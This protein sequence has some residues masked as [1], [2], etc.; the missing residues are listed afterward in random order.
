MATTYRF[1][2]EQGKGGL[3]TKEAE[4]LKENGGLVGGAGK[5]GLAAGVGTKHGAGTYENRWLRIVNPAINKF[6][7]GNWEK[8]T[9]IGRGVATMPS[10]FASGGIG[11]VLSSTGFA[12][13]LQLA[14][15]MAIKEFEKMRANSLKE[16]NANFLRM[17]SGQTI[18][19]QNY[20]VSKDWFSGKITYRNQ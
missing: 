15:M 11:A 13:I 9:R 3:T 4:V 2:F 8:A 5:G 12:I 17:E 6:T 14:I 7:G 20:S 16:N 18:L 10:T 1:L 19:S